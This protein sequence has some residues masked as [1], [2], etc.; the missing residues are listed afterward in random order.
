M[1]MHDVDALVI[2]KI[3][4]LQNVSNSQILDFHQMSG[5][6]VFG[7]WVFLTENREYF[8]PLLFPTYFQ[9][10]SCQYTTASAG[11]FYFKDPGAPLD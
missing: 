2:Y 8:T 10:Q 5:M 11:P 4:F 3:T 9:T 7:F 1:H 6:V